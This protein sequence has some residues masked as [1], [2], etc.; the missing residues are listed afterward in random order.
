M[1]GWLN[2]GGRFAQYRPSA[3]RSSTSARFRARSALDWVSTAATILIAHHQLW[4]SSA[5]A[6][7][8][9]RNSVAIPIRRSFF[10]LPHRHRVR[11]RREFAVLP[12]ATSIPR[13]RQQ[14]LRHLGCSRR[15]CASSRSC[16]PSTVEGHAVCRVRT[17]GTWEGCE[18]RDDRGLSFF[19]FPP[20]AQHLVKPSVLLL[21]CSRCQKQCR[22]YPVM[23]HSFIAGPQS[24][25]GTSSCLLLNP[26]PAP[27]QSARGLQDSIRC[28]RLRGIN[29]VAFRSSPKGRWFPIWDGVDVM[30]FVLLSSSATGDGC[31]SPDQQ[32]E[33]PLCRRTSKGTARLT[34]R[35]KLP[36]RV[37]L[38]LWFTDLCLSMALG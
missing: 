38:R 6:A 25:G 1:E 24:I 21:C 17:T 7:P 15:G 2:L 13:G 19:V 27:P 28:V 33:W 36:E 11:A 26:N 37:H 35:G 34:G 32:R 14:R 20:V 18:R 31:A 4:H 9:A 23:S 22:R 3:Q 16:D 29:G 5:C 12:V 10:I 8:V 30:S